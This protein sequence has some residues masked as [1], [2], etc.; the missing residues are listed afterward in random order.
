MII[1]LKLGQRQQVIPIVLP[2]INKEMKVLFQL[3]VDFLCLAIALWVVCSCH[4]KLDA[5]ELMEFSGE[6]GNKL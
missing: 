2:L 1:I 6:L 5:E 4:R 3:L